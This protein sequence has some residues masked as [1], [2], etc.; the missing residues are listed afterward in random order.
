MVVQV[1]QGVSIQQDQQLTDMHEQ[2]ASQS[3]MISQLQDQLKQHQAQ[4]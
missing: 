1:Q 2:L 4:L 3:N